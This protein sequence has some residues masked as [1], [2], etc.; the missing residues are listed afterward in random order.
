MSPH[1]DENHESP[2]DADELIN[3][4]TF[5]GRLGVRGEGDVVEL[6]QAKPLAVHGHAKVAEINGLPRGLRNLVCGRSRGFALWRQVGHDDS[7]DGR[8][9]QQQR[10]GRERARELLFQEAAAKKITE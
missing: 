1:P 8:Q 6:A 10:G 2:S 9:S 4:V 7:A 3:N 5:V